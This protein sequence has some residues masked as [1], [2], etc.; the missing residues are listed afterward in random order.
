MVSYHPIPLFQNDQDGMIRRFR[1]IVYQHN[2]YLWY[3]VVYICIGHIR[4]L[5]EVF[6]QWHKQNI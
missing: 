3:R 4:I 2:L 5:L 6:A 1:L